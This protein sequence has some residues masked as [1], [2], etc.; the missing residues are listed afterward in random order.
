MRRRLL[1]PLFTDKAL[2]KGFEPKSL[3]HIKKFCSV[4][5]P[6]Q[7]QKISADGWGPEIDMTNIFSYMVFDALN[8]FIFGLD[9]EMLEKHDNRS[10]IHD[11][12]E[13]LRRSAVLLYFPF[14]FIGRIDKAFFPKA[15]KAGRKISNYMR[16]TIQE[17]TSRA[18]KGESDNNVLSYLQN[19]R[20]PGTGELL[21]PSE[22]KAEAV[23]LTMA[24]KYFLKIALDS[25]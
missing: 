23:I 12:E 11:M 22:S 17:H 6:N 19:T 20:D 7:A 8:D 24:G 15:E 9:G 1:G 21:S 16:G 10:I 2:K 3:S 5:N 4:I 14:L 18:R 25:G 13:L